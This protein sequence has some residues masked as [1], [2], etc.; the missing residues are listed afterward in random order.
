MRK[1]LFGWAL[2]GLLWSAPLYG[3]PNPIGLVKAVTGDATILRDGSRLAATPGLLLF[4]GDV[5]RTGSAGTP[6]PTSW[7]PSWPSSTSGARCN[8]S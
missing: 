6:T 2:G 4:K 1:A 3:Q 5:L 7:T 8:G